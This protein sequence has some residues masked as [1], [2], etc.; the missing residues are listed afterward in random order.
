ML[1]MNFVS[2]YGVS[3]PLALTAHHVS[4]LL[5]SSVTAADRDLE[6]D[7]LVSRP[8]LRL[9]AP[10]LVLFDRRGPLHFAVRPQLL[11]RRSPLPRGEGNPLDRLQ[12]PNTLVDN[13]SRIA[14][15]ETQECGRDDRTVAIGAMAPITPADG[16]QV[17]GQHGQPPRAIQSRLMLDSRVVE[18]EDG[19]H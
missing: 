9:S 8:P 19:V 14:D 10:S 12:H 3:V 7:L 13:R 1:G 17:H 11:T 18:Y 15:T 5:M 4:L 2:R 6:K 16:G